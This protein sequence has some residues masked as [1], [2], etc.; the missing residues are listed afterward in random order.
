MVLK[1]YALSLAY[2]KVKVD[3]VENVHEMYDEWVSVEYSNGRLYI[4]ED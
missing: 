3:N 4:D 2:P 1:N